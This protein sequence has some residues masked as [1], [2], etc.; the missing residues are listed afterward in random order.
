M[1]RTSIDAVGGG[2]IRRELVPLVGAREIAAALGVG[3]STVLRWA[4]VGVLP[5]YRVGRLVRFDPALVA[6]ALRAQPP[7][8]EE[9]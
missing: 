7:S 1:G 6:T 3:R 5:S 2:H 8:Q 4:A 9:K